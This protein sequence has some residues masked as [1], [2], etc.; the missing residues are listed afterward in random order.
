MHENAIDTAV[1]AYGP[2]L[3]RNVAS[4]RRIPAKGPDG[5]GNDGRIVF[6]KGAAGKMG[7]IKS[8]IRTT[9]IAA[10]M[11]VLAMGQFWILPAPVGLCVIA[12]PP[13]EKSDRKEKALK[14]KDSKAKQN[15]HFCFFYP[16]YTVG[17]LKPILP[18]PPAQ[19][20]GLAAFASHRQ[21]GNFTPPG[22]RFLY[23]HDSTHDNGLFIA[24]AISLAKIGEIVW[25][26]NWQNIWVN[27]SMAFCI[28]YYMAHKGGIGHWNTLW[29]YP[30]W[31]LN[32]VR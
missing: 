10:G 18:V 8:Q 31:I 5:N 20:R 4:V 3:Q 2:P 6:Q 15:K 23:V 16:D 17:D 1:G 19:A 9:E 25:R 28:F 22:N 11:A 21:W 24:K 26:G 14:S 32:C 13:H 29:A 12:I 30:I 27:L 7:E